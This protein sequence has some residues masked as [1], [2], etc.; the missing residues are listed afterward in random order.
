MKQ[1]WIIKQC[2]NFY[3]SFLY[4]G[5]SMWAIVDPTGNYIKII[6]WPCKQCWGCWPVWECRDWLEVSFSSCSGCPVAC[7]LNSDVHHSLRSNVS[8]SS[9][10]QA[11]TT[12]KQHTVTGCIITHAIRITSRRIRFVHK[13]LPTKFRLDA[14]KADWFSYSSNE[15]F[16]FGCCLNLLENG[17][18]VG[19]KDKAI[20]YVEILLRIERKTVARNLISIYIL[21]LMAIE[22]GR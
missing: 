20:V 15:L 4:K 8:Q 6:T 21:T 3:Y 17:E 1:C 22:K 13:S 16:S 14:L 18:V 12:R 9:R 11:E 2:W 7:L 5:S 19:R 10:P